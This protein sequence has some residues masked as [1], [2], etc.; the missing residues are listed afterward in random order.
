M[1]ALEFWFRAN[2]SFRT[3]PSHPITIPR[4]QVPHRSLVEA[5]LHEG[6]FTLVFPRGERRTAEMCSGVSGR[7]PFY[8]LRVRGADRLVPEYIKHDDPLLILLVR[9]QR[10]SFAFIENVE[11]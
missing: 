10:K 7:G 11:F 1:A 6:P 2:R 3:T 4:G 8:Q 5:Q 9:F